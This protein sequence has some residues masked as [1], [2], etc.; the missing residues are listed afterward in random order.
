MIELRRDEATHQYG[1]RQFHLEDGGYEYFMPLDESVMPDCIRTTGHGTKVVLM[2]RAAEDDTMRPP[3]GTPSPSRWI[4]KYL[5][6]RYYEFPDNVTVRAREGWEN[7]RTDKDKNVLRTLTGQRKYLDSHCEEKGE[8]E[9]PGAR[10]RWWI[11]KD[12]PAKTNNSGFIESAGHIAALHKSELYDRLT[13]RAGGI[14]LQQF[15]ITFGAPFVVLYV[16]PI[17]GPTRSITTNTARTT[18]LVN[19]E[20][21]PWE[22]WAADFREKLPKRLA[23]FV[24][25]KAAKA[26]GSD[27]SKTIRERLRDLLDLY[28]VSRYR[29]TPQGP[30]L[31]DPDTIAR[32]SIEPDASGRAAT[33]SGGDGTGGSGTPGRKQ[34]E[35]GNVYHLFEKKG[36]LGAAKA[37]GDPFPQVSWISARTGSREKGELEDRAAQYLKETN[38]LKINEDF[39]VF[40]DMVEHYNQELGGH[41]ATLEAVRDIV[42][43]W[44]EQALIETVIGVQALRNS[45]EWSVE[46]IDN[47]LSE[48]ALTAAVM[49]RY[50][51]N[52]AVRRELGSKFGKLGA[53]S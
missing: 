5:N 24:A 10:V 21:L 46:D 22:E 19:N 2:G 43:G 12:E 45:R 53:K 11:L 42:H 15:G 13:A 28:K 7:P 48:V 32:M 40:R 52:F 17:A 51:V 34:T 31:V 16:E 25:E 47:A 14:R 9:I 38:V 49:Q 20:P 8:H 6:S 29:P 4:S 50:H 33:T 1:L 37:K 3:A 27:H 41:D 26:A 18:L 30:L 23:E 44:F 39:R 36:G 35:R